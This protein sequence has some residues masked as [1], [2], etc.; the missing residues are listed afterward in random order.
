MTTSHQL[1]VA[2]LVGKISA[3]LEIRYY[4]LRPKAQVTIFWDRDCTIKVAIF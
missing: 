2:P 4:S 1:N 3:A